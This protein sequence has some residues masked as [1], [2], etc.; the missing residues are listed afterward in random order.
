LRRWIKRN[1]L[2]YTSLPTETWWYRILRKIFGITKPK[3]HYHTA[4]EVETYLS[5]NGFSR[6]AAS[7]VPCHFKLFPLFSICAWRK[8]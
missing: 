6:I 4:Q 3:D 1:G 7:Y 5:S 8:A 2:L